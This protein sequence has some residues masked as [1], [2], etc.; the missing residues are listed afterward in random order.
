MIGDY[1]ADYVAENCSR[2]ERCLC[3]FCF[4]FLILTG[5]LRKRLLFFRVFRLTTKVYESR[6]WRETKGDV[7]RKC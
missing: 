5:L 7:L 4:F 6:W 3:F 1:V 2:D